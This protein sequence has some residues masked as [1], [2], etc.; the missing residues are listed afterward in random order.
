MEI[1]QSFKTKSIFLNSNFI[2]ILILVLI[3][4]PGLII[5]LAKE[6]RLE[7]SDNELHIAF[8]MHLLGIKCT[9]KFRFVIHAAS[10]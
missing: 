9:L 1:C 2:F 10:L 4:D 3:A 7:S 6:I 8:T 5:P